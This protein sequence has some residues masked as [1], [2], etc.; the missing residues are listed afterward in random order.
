M[1][2]EL[3]HFVLVVDHGTLTAAARK[4]HLSQPAL[5]ASL[6]RL[7]TSFGAR[8]L[9]RGPGGAELTAAGA[10]LLPRGRAA[11]GAGGGRG[12]V[13][14]VQGLR[15]GEVRLGAGATAC[16]YLLPPLLAEFRSKHPAVRFLLRELTP[17]QVQDALLKSE[18][19][20]GVVTSPDGEP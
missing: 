3:Q 8:L 15:A 20:L 7:E 19:D 12:A 6:Q 10:A 16:T 17:E 1:L 11:A 4:A 9:H 5:T 2:E 18:I 13:S 14:E